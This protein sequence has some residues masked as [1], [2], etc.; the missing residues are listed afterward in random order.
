MKK[1]LTGS[2]QVVLN[3]MD[4]TTSVDKYFA[5]DP[6]KLNRAFGECKHYI[7]RNK[8]SF[9]SDHLDRYVAIWLGLQSNF[10]QISSFM[11]QLINYVTDTQKGNKIMRSDLELRT[12]LNKEKKLTLEKNVEMWDKIIKASIKNLDF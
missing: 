7:E 12:N 11:D 8:G 6:T 5:T 2:G 3:N 4:W 9:S 10:R 1:E